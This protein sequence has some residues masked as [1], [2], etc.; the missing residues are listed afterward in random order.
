MCRFLEAGQGGGCGPE[1]LAA[2]V[3]CASVYSGGI[4]MAPFHNIIRRHTAF[5]RVL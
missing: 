3:P 2:T 1:Q 4:A 5:G